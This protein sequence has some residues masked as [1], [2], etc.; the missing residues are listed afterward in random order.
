MPDKKKTTSKPTPKTP[1]AKVVNQSAE[2]IRAKSDAMSKSM[3]EQSVANRA[4]IKKQIRSAIM[5]SVFMSVLFIIICIGAAFLFLGPRFMADVGDTASQQVAAIE[6]KYDDLK[7]AQQALKEKQQRLTR[8]VETFMAADLFEQVG[9]VQNLSAQMRTINER[10]ASLNGSGAGKAVLDESMLDLQ[11]TV[12]GMSNRVENLEVALEGAK[13]DNDALSDMLQGITGKE[14][15]AAAMLMAVS[16]LRQS[17]MQDGGFEQDLATVRA[18]A[19]DDPETLAALEKI[20]PYAREGIVSRDALK[21]EFRGLAG[22]IVSAKLKGEDV[23]FQDKLF[24]RMDN[25]VQVRKTGMVEGEDTKAVVARAETLMNQ[26]DIRAAITELEKLD[27]APRETAQP[28][29]DDAQARMLAETLSGQLTSNVIGKLP[30]LNAGGASSIMETVKGLSGDTI[31]P[32][33][34][35]GVIDAIKGT[36]GGGGASGPVTFGN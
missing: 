13:Q 7:Q 10:I 4:D 27:G 36:V 19:G 18:L 16:Q 35:T 14:L 24:A 26:G 17:L 33:S 1:S 21:S 9:Q 15:K 12:L 25:F 32:D 11:G 8:Q 34:V 29:I 30:T 20:T 22:D 28:F 23:S 3:D 6:Q 2:D 31:S 5:R